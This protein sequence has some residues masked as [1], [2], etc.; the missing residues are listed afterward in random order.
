MKISSF[1]LLFPVRHENNT[2]TIK[3][4]LD[5]AVEVIFL[6]F[7]YVINSYIVDLSMN[8]I[9][10]FLSRGSKGYWLLQRKI[11]KKIY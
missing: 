3:I 1:I 4:G 8:K 9:L 5:F 2:K 7:H 6:P 11:N 10:V